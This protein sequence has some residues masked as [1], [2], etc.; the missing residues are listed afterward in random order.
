[1]IGVRK[2]K[3]SRAIGIVGGAGPM[4]SA[5][6]YNTI[7]EICQKEYASND[8]N[9]FP[10]IIIESYPFT[11]GENIKHA[12]ALCFTKLKNAGAEIFSIASNS[13]HGYLPDVSSI[14]FVNLVTE[15]LKEASRLKVTKAIDMKL[16]ETGLQCVYPNGEDQKHIQSMIR[17]VAG[18]EVTEHQAAK[19]EEII[20][21][22]TQIDGVII[23][24]TEIPL[25]LRKFPLQVRLPMIDTV[26]V[27]A[28]KLVALSES[29][30]H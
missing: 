20:R 16:Y 17:E 22:H 27:L 1:L 26:E 12:I 15:S 6:M 10:E 7:I 29:S 28:K 4:A 24:C 13:F 23:A 8:Y 9:E 3:F 25:I 21:K 14:A 30:G 2:Q 19:L 5:Y 11:R 18:G